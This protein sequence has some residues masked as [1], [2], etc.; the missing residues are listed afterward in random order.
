MK[1]ASDKISSLKEAKWP[2][3]IKIRSFLFFA[4][5]SEKSSVHILKTLLLPSN[6][7]IREGMKEAHNYA[8]M[9]MT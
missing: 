6:Y 3:F 9:R 7:T 8:S 2:N 4:I 1:I 5:Y